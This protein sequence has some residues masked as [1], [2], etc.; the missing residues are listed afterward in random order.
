MTDL[1]KVQATALGL[2]NNPEFLTQEDLAHTYQFTV[3][4]YPTVRGASPGLI[5]Y[6]V[7]HFLNWSHRDHKPE[8][9]IRKQLAIIQFVFLVDKENRFTGK[10]E[11]RFCED[12][13]ASYREGEFIFERQVD[14]I[15]GW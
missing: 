12:I 15:K 11:G 2:V 14:Y 4:V 13:E 9:S 8:I 10:V 1:S 3:Q 5:V 6:V 7:A